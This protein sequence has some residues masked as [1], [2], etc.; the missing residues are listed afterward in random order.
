MRLQDRL[1]AHLR[2]P[3]AGLVLQLF[4]VILLP[5]TLLLVAITFGSIS[6]HNQAMRN[7]V[8]ERDQRAVSIAASAL[9]DQVENRW[10]EIVY[11]SA[12]LVSDP[13]VPANTALAHL[14]NMPSGFDAGLAVF[15]ADGNL[16][17][18]KGETDFWK[19]WTGNRRDWPG[20]YQAVEQNI[21]VWIVVSNP[22]YP[23]VYG[24][25]AGKAQGSQILVGA[26]S[27][28][29]LA[30]STLSD[31]LPAGGDL[32]ILL[33]STDHQIL[34]SVGN[35][36]DQS[37]D[38]PGVSQ[39]LQGQTG[40]TYVK[41]G[42]DEHVTAYSPVPSVGWALITE[43]S[44]EAVATPAL[45]TSQIV[46][47]VLVPAVLILLVALYLSAS[48]VVRP[49]RQLES[50]ASNLANGEFAT[51]QQP[52]GGIAEIRHL[53][54]ELVRMANRV[55]EAQRS[56]HRY[57][58]AITT[59]Q[60]EERRRLARELHDDTLQA[61]IALQQRVQLAQLE[62]KPAA[63]ASAPQDAGLGEVASLTERTIENLRR[64]TRDL[65][66]VY[67][68]DLGLV[69]ALEML[70]R[71]TGQASGID[72]TFQRR[73]TE[74]RL[75][76]AVELALYRMA[77]EACSNIT[78]HARAKH[79]SVEIDYGRSEITLQVQDDGL[80]FDLA[81]NTA[82]FAASD[83][84]GLLG[85]RERAE[86]IGASL[87]IRTSPGKGTRILVSIPG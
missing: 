35:L 64:V 5:L 33:V 25:I 37:A 10:H 83:H 32:S 18:A 78:R 60:E 76:P 8:G 71:E 39:A 84:F 69:P 19:T 26:Y 16:V 55:Q 75:S 29:A 47:L 73:G 85:L 46:P 41:V 81:S 45:R 15:T 43:E 82:R 17:G 42:G 53:Q 67:L 27:I 74:R 80:G 58:G 57:I 79:A 11:L 30:A 23:G 44:W 61:L 13:S 51:I 40:T 6:I 86:L 72:C 28:Q 4:A 48:Q 62:M 3:P 31:L 2:L 70:A 7:L 1:K 9:N 14:A 50:K 59:A 77:Q 87:D 54:D 22:P 38:H 66:P 49:L 65:R 68:E 24:L 21:G 36:S 20:F 34:Y 63:K 52:V 12:L 56:L